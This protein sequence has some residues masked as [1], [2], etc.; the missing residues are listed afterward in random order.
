MSGLVSSC[1]SLLWLTYRRD[2]PAL[3]GDAD[4][5]EGE[6]GLTSDRGWG[7]MLRCGQMVLAE[8]LKRWVGNINW[9]SALF[10]RTTCYSSPPDT[11]WVPPGV[12]ILPLPTS[13][14][15]ILASP[16]CSPTPPR[17]DSA[18]TPWQRRA[19][20]RRES[21]WARG[22]GQTRSHRQL[23]RREIIIIRS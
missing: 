10:D 14:P 23:G 1:R 7:C 15:P 6:G 20:L 3:G 5:P 12:G 22:S 8:A 13:T 19:E 4:D 16:P 9:V 11:C 17:P 21:H 2:F 18:S